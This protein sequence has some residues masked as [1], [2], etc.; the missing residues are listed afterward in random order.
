MHPNATLIQRLFSSLNEHDHEGMAACYHLQAKFKDIAFDLNGKK[1][2]HA[3][4]HMICQP[5]AHTS[6]I[7]VMFNVVHADD[8]RGWVNLVDDY[9]FS[10]TGR[11]VTNIIDSHFY[12]EDGLIVEQHD[13]CDPRAWSEMALG[14]LGGFLAAQFHSLR[15]FKARQMLR[16]FLRKHAE[17][18]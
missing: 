1:E 4:W 15:S 3:M 8:R 12:F 2:I 18:Q 5:D 9:T 10:P 14:G 6:D 17:Y 11:K 13:F 16:E 7:C